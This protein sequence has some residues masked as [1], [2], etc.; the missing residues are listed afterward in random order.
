MLKSP[1]E[2]YLTE[3]ITLTGSYTHNN[4]ITPYKFTGIT[5]DEI[6]CLSGEHMNIQ[7]QFDTINAVSDTAFKVVSGLIELMEDITV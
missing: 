1:R 4:T 3:N 5:P 6:H 2:H 7:Q